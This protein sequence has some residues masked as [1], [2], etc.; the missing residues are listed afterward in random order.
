MK[1]NKKLTEIESEFVE[2]VKQRYKALSKGEPRIQDAAPA[3]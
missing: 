2:S 1:E 3:E